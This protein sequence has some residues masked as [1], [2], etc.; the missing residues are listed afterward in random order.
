M[1]V[2]V[3]PTEFGHHPLQPPSWP[4]KFCQ[5]AR[6]FVP[7][8]VTFLLGRRRLRSL[9]LPGQACRAGTVVNV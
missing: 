7:S 2:S 9:F 5:E 3:S 8:P 6:L 1:A 4:P